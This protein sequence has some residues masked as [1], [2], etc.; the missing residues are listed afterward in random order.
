M[1]SRGTAAQDGT[2]GTRR[3]RFVGTALA[4]LVLG[5]GLAVTA[6]A[7]GALRDNQ[8]A[9]ADRVM[10]QRTALARAAV[11]GETGRYRDLIQVVAAGLGTNVRL[12]A[13]D[14][15]AATAPLERAGL[16]GATSVA[17]VVA[18]SPGQIPATQRLWRSRGVTGLVLR[19][20]G[21]PREHLFSVLRRDLNH[22]G[23][24]TLGVDVASAPE[25]AAALAESRRTGQPSVSDAYVL[26]RDR[27]LP[28]PRQQLSFMFAAPVF[29]AGALPEFRGWLALGLRG[30]DFL[31]GVLGTASQGLLDGELYATDGSGRRVQVAAYDARGGRDLIRQASFPVADRHWALLTAADAR[32][33]PGARSSTP[34]AVL[35]GGIAVSVMLALLV[36]VLATGRHRARAQVLLATADL[37]GAEAESRRQAGLL[38]AIMASLGDGVGVVDDQGR[39]LLHN[40]AAKALLGVADDIE[41]PQGWQEHYGLFRADGRTPF[42]VEELPLVRALHGEAS[43]DVEMVIRNENRP[44]GILVSV[45][46]RPLDPSA[47]LR[48]AV[49]VFHDITELRR[50]E[51]D[52][53]VFAGVVAH[54]LKAPLSVIRGHCETAADE[55]ADAAPV[56]EVTAARASLDRI[57]RAVDRMAAMIDTLLAYT[58]ARDAPLTLRAVPLGP[59][60]AEVVEHRTEQPRPAGTPPP[61]IYVGPLPVVEA[62]PAMLRHVLDN[63]VGNALKYVPPGRPARIDVAATPADPGWT[64]V[65]VADRGIG[66][67][68][69]DQPAIFE[70]F[71]RARSAAGYAGTGLGLAICRR[72]VERHGGAIGVADNPGGGTRFFFTLPLAATAPDERAAL[73]RACAERAAIGQAALPRPEDDDERPRAGPLRPAGTAS[74]PPRTREAGPAGRA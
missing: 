69:E 47:G 25:A 55:L 50:Y 71:H 51:T 62:D 37:R 40:P 70:A 3:A 68:A 34:A 22:G 1:G 8:R 28:A 6:F 56:P 23:A 32:Y 74:D 36:W 49:A 45:D 43:D 31:G 61:E 73:D 29:G 39:F 46:G 7:A 12:T 53:A 54:D 64:R 59:L 30:R 13:A 9:Q 63:L 42:P 72:I 14:F 4:A 41:G 20:H 48:G 24:G 2:A 67:P 27:G 10:D 44:D 16:V 11:T 17:F 58:T 18:T 5:P 66:I 15:A 35:H 21:T 60:V 52:L 57:A 19:P 33:L 26:L 65:E 38:S